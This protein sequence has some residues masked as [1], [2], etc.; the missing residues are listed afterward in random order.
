MQAIAFGHPMFEAIGYIGFAG[1]KHI[2]E[3]LMVGVEAK[4]DNT[5][6]AVEHI[7]VAHDGFVSI[8]LLVG[9]ASVDTKERWEGHLKT[10]ISS[11]LPIRPAHVFD[12]SDAGGDGF[13][14]EHIVDEM[15]R[16]RVG[17]MIEF[18][19]F[20]DERFEPAYT[21]GFG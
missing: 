16:D 3:F 18:H 11:I 20:G 15:V 14:G 12:S 4:I 1:S 9:I 21:E 7:T 8:N 19:F 17:V 6:I 2:S 10:E 5:N 13:V